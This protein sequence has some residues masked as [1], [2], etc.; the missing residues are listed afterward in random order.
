MIEQAF[1]ILRR[2]RRRESEEEL[3]VVLQELGAGIRELLGPG[4]ALLERMD[5]AS[6][7]ALLA[8]ANRAA[9]W[10]RLLAERASL[11]P[12]TAPV[13]ARV[14]SVRAAEL[15]LETREQVRAGAPITAEAEEALREAL[16]IALEI[17]GAEAL[18]P[19]YAALAARE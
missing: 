14:A 5:A 19:R 13:E 15:A 9:V 4:A 7:V 2:I 6:A 8:D 11:L 16:T 3:P 17:C 1:R 10:A 18:T 12:D